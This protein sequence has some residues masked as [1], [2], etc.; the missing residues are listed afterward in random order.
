MTD[1]QIARE[2]QQ[3]R[4]SLLY[5]V[6]IVPASSGNGGAMR[7]GLLLRALAQHYKISLLI[8][9]LW[10]PP[11]TPV[12]QETTALCHRIAEASIDDR[13]S[14][15]SHVF[16]ALRHYD[17]PVWDRAE[18]P[19][20]GPGM[21]FAD[22]H[23]DV[24]HVS[25][26]ITLLYLDVYHA[27]SK[28]SALHLDLYDIESRK[29]ERLAEIYRLNGDR[30]KALFQKMFARRFRT[31]EEAHLH[32][33]DRVYVCS[34]T[35]KADLESRVDGHFHVIPNAV[36]V[37]ETVPAVRP[38]ES[39]NFLFVGTMSYYP[40][41]D[42]AEYFCR[43]ILPLVRAS[44]P[45]PFTVTIVGGG[46]SGETL[47]VAN[48]P[49]VRLA[50][51][52]PDMKPWYEVTDAVVVPLRAGSGTRLKVL[53]AF[54]YGIPVVTTT[55]GVEGIEANPEEHILLADTPEQF[56]RQCVRL[57]REP[58]LRTRLADRAFQLVSNNY[59]ETAVMRMVAQLP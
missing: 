39:F 54:A 11:G 43:E 49:D 8:V 20:S 44:A 18:Q 34:S 56:A 13:Q 1:G 25:V 4:G 31:F 21:P 19:H 23:F 42:A 29:C 55:I 27:W 30:D 40:N 15:A 48:E 46:R 32:R 35:D 53:E 26:I 47:N 38:H 52:V 50:G 24:V 58:G 17:N 9:P 14:L 10:N 45:R 5:V 57:M 6:P 41:R 37:P 51:R 2:P 12:P 28:R 59:S 16:T 36:R 33:F 7:A 3:T 22:Q